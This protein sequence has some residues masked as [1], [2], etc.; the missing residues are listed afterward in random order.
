MQEATGLEGY[1]YASLSP[2]GQYRWTLTRYWNAGPPICWVMLNPSTAD[3]ESDDPT[4][5][6]VT[7]F[8]KAWGSGSLSVVNL[9]PY[10]ATDPARCRRWADWGH[11]GPDWY[12][13]D[14][15]HKNA[16]IVGAAARH[17]QMT[18]LAWGAAPWAYEWAEYVL[19]G[20]LEAGTLPLPTLYCLSRNKDGSPKH[21]LARGR[22]R[23]PTDQEPIPWAGQR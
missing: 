22:N 14:A 21:P 4:I 19:D 20:H 3:A 7:R 17:A 11:N 16:E 13:R 8:S 1:G 12:A 15:L 5:R 9:Y 2:D 23:V 6:T 18:I 10:R